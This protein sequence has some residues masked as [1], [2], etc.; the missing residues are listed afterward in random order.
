MALAYM[1]M[2]LAPK[3]IPSIMCGFA[4]IFALILGLKVVPV[5]YAN[6]ISKN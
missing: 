4:I 5:Y 2:G 3:T 6:R 1:T